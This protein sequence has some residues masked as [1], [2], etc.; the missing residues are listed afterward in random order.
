MNC[1]THTVSATLRATM[2]TPTGVLVQVGT[3]R[4]LPFEYAPLENLN[5]LTLLKELKRDAF[6]VE[7]RDVPFSKCTVK[8]F[9]S[10]KEDATA[11]EAEDDEELKGT[12]TLGALANDMTRATTRRR[13]GSGSERRRRVV[14]LVDLD[15]SPER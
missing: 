11:T 10:A 15:A 7:L 13:R 4:P 5:V 14:A 9:A 3:G 1:S 12:K 2:T 8:L 6:E